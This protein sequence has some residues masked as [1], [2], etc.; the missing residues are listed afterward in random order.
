MNS[1]VI[2]LVVSYIS[3]KMS[4]ILPTLF[5][6]EKCSSLFREKNTK[7]PHH[8]WIQFQVIQIHGGTYIDE[9]LILIQIK[10]R[11]KLTHWDL[12]I[13]YGE[14]DLGQPF[15]TGSDNG[16]SPDSTKPLP[17]P[18]LTSWTVF[19]AIH[20]RAISEVLMNLIRNVFGRYTLK[21]TT[22]PSD[23]WVK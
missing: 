2:F 14:I 12:V 4:G 23:Q 8:H 5:C 15:E 3:G 11:W 16:F 18:M 1:E 9:R 6:D 7:K 13:Q 22:S 19:C 17:E 20:L 10:T 21:I